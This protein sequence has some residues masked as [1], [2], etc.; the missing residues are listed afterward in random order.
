MSLVKAGSV[1]QVS[2]VTRLVHYQA[3]KACYQFKVTKQ[4]KQKC[5]YYKMLPSQEMHKIL[6]VY[7]KIKQYKISFFFFLVNQ[8]KFSICGD[9]QKQMTDF[10]MKPRQYTDFFF[11]LQTYTSLLNANVC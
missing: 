10:S 6:P 7:L 1:G 8:I 9:V 2:K 4:C 5:I 11:G 3:T